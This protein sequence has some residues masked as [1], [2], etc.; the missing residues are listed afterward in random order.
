MLRFA[1]AQKLGCVQGVRE[2]VERPVWGEWSLQGRGSEYLELGW[3]GW[4]RVFSLAGHAQDF[5][6]KLSA[7]EAAGESSA[8]K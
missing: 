1:D 7:R 4:G 8:E 3:Q 5:A 6:L 2:A